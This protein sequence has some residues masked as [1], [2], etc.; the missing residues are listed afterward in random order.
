MRLPEDND[1]GRL[2]SLVILVLVATIAWLGLWLPIL[3]IFSPSTG[4]YLTGAIASLGT[5][6]VAILT[7]RAV[8]R[9][10]R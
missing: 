1:L 3:L 8:R 5:L 9:N 6:V 7:A 2:F 4:V 10:R